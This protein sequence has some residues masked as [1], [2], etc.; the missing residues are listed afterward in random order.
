MEINQPRHFIGIIVWGYLSLLTLYAALVI[1]S[2]EGPIW[3]RT[4]YC[5]VPISIA[6]PLVKLLIKCSDKIDFQELN[7][8]WTF[9]VNKPQSENLGGLTFISILGVLVSLGLKSY[10]YSILLMQIAG[11]LGFFVWMYT[12]METECG[13]CGARVLAK[14]ALFCSKCGKGFKRETKKIDLNYCSKCNQPFKPNSIHCTKCG[15]KLVADQTANP[16]GHK[17]PPRSKATSSPCDVI[18]QNPGK[19]K[20]KI[21]KEVGFFTGLR[22][23]DAKKLVDTAPNTVLSNAPKSTAEKAKKVL[24]AAGATVTIQI[25]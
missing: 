22:L 16:P 6:G 2:E 12:K 17:A 10:F 4:L 13:S 9:K 18:L 7:T 11:V 14:N 1:I 20:I 3:L 25:R 23:K 21:I 5:F 15:H 19:N 8:D 24:E